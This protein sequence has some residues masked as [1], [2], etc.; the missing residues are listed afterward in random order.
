MMRFMIVSVLF[1]LINVGVLVGVFIY[2]YKKYI[3]KPLTDD[4]QQAHGAVAHLEH[5]LESAKKSRHTHEQ[6]L[7]DDMQLITTLKEKVVLWRM[8]QHRLLTDRQEYKK[9]RIAQLQEQLPIKQQ[10]I[11]E[12]MAERSGM[13]AIIESSRQMLATRFEQ[14]STVRGYDDAVLSLLKRESTPHERS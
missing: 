6:Q 2:G 4:M 7:R 1:R 5:T 13:D 10:R 12:Y 3:K 14:E 11:A 9:L 8:V